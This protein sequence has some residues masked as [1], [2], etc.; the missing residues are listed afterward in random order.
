MS[1]SN[2]NIEITSDFNISDDDHITKLSIT[3]VFDRQQISWLFNELKK[4][5][6]KTDIILKH[7]QLTG[8]HPNTYLY[9]F[10]EPT[11]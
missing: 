2:L 5:R 3:T 4:D 7:W 6:E 10:K 9:Y 11:I 8:I 1:E